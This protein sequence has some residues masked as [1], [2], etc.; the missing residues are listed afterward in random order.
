MLAEIKAAETDVVLVDE[1][2]KPV[3]H[4][5]KLIAHRLGQL[6][7]AVSVFVFDH[8][9][10][11]LLQRRA[12]PKYHSGGLWSNTACTHPQPAESVLDAARRCL[13]DEMG[14]KCALRRAGQLTYR[15]PVGNGLVEY[16]YDIL[17]TGIFEGDPH[18][19]PAEVSDW[20]WLGAAEARRDADASP[21]LYSA[22]FALAFDALRKPRNLISRASSDDVHAG[23]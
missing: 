18:P 22:W 4:Q 3:G 19:N 17:F 11:L 5:D 8:A 21:A 13:H 6:H 1:T 10:R 16:E 2:G 7:L 23:S 20:R 15:C 9:Q 12:D 14:L